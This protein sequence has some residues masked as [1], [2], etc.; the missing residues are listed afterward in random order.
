MWSEEVVV[1][2]EEGGEGDRTVGGIESTGGAGMEAV[3]ADKSFN[4]L[5]EGSKFF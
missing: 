4:E 3:G 5:L 1:G 2:G